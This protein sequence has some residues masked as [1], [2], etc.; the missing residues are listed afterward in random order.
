MKKGFFKKHL[1]AYA[2]ITLFIINIATV[3]IFREK[4]RISSYSYLPMILLAFVLVL[5]ALAYISKDARVFSFVGA[6]KIHEST[7]G[8]RFWKYNQPTAADLEYFRKT[9]KIYFSPIPF[10]IPL[11][12]FSTA[13]AHYL[14]CLPLILIPQLTFI[15]IEISATLRDVKEAKLRK[16]QLEKDRID[17]ERR[18]E[19]GRWK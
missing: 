5:G 3:F 9:A 10:Y 12:F 6:C 13:V 4:A 8:S 7:A 17:Q 1:W 16:K 2:F 15:G 11:I 18:E 19:L 14:W